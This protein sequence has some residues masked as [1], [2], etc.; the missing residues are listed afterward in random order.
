M[1]WYWWAVAGILGL[2]ALVVAVVAL[3]LA[4]DWFR[5]RGAAPEEG[6]D[7]GKRGAA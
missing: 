4:A 5:A 6:Q 2:N 3:F 7:T 1:A